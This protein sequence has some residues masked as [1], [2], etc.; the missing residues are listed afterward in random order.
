MGPGD[1]PPLILGKKRKNHRGKKSWQG[2]Q[3]KTASPFS[4]S[5]GAVTALFIVCSIV[6]LKNI[7]P[8]M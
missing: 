2:K 5:S 6:P 3:N 8:V 7:K 1:L 4:S